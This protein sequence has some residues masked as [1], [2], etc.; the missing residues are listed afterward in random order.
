MTQVHLTVLV[1]ESWL[2]RFSSV[3]EQC[4]LTGMDI[5]RELDTVGVIVG[6][7]DAERV[8][9]LRCLEGVLEV[10]VERLITGYRQKNQRN[11]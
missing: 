10:E 6:V 4:R 3:V 1:S 7:I 5:E 8:S 11:E 9:D 2:D